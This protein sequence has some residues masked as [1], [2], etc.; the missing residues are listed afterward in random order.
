MQVISHCLQLQ[1]LL[2]RRSFVFYGALLLITT[3]GVET[4]HT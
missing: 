4:T 1:I 3:S 2:I